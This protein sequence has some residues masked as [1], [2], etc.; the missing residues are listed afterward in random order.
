MSET[1]GLDNT[2]IH[3]SNKIAKIN[4][5][6]MFDKWLIRRIRFFLLCVHIGRLNRADSTLSDCV[7]RNLLNEGGN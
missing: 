1:I 3:K 7:I 4:R 6:F 2:A 5:R